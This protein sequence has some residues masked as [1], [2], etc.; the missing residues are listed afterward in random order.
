VFL[1]VAELLFFV[2]IGLI[3]L[4]TT[5]PIFAKRAFDE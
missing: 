3:S 4:Q 1:T 5:T 2:T